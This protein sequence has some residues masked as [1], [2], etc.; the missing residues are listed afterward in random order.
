MGTRSWQ[1]EDYVREGSDYPAVNVR[2]DD[3]VA[4]CRKLSKQEGVEYRLPTEAEW[5]YACR[6]GT[7]TAYSFGDDASKL[8]QYAWYDKNSWEWCQDWYGPYGGEAGSDP[9]GPA[10]GKSKQGQ[11][12]FQFRLLRG[13]AFGTPPSD[14]RSAYRGHLQPVVRSSGL[15]FRVARTYNLSP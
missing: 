10:R 3:A 8:G 1:G 14:V 13:G 12:K 11:G 4:F 2:H 6:A 15:G 7:T 9:K 5:E